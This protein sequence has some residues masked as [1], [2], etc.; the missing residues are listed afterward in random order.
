M[1]ADDFNIFQFFDL[2]LPNDEVENT[3]QRSRAE[4][5]RWGRKHR[6]TFD[7]AKEHLVIIHPAQGDGET[8]KLLGTLIDPQ[9]TMQACIDSILSK[10]KP[11]IKALLRTRAHYHMTT[12]I[13]QF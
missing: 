2:S 4:V 9:L 6:V 5:H 1:F 11:K 12:M 13:N 8:F 7:A 3:L 10:I